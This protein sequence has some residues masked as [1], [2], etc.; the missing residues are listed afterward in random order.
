MRI[1]K[2]NFNKQLKEVAYAVNCG[3]YNRECY[4]KSDVELESIV[5]E[6]FGIILDAL[7]DAGVNFDEFVVPVIKEFNIEL[8]DDKLERIRLRNTDKSLPDDLLVEIKC[9]YIEGVDEW[10]PAR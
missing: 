7:S 1:V 5:W 9:P 3:K 2:E 10:Y 6:E 4:S 8:N